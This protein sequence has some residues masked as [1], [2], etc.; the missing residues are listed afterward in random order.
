MYSTPVEGTAVGSSSLLR[1]YSYVVRTE[2]LESQGNPQHSATH[3]RRTAYIRTVRSS[4]CYGPAA[5]PTTA[6]CLLFCLLIGQLRTYIWRCMLKGSK[7]DNKNNIPIILFSAVAYWGCSDIA[8]VIRKLCG[9]WAIL[10]AR[11]FWFVECRR[12]SFKSLLCWW[13]NLDCYELILY[14]TFIL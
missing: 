10:K 4:R 5:H 1:R 9:N 2:R 8:Y 7:N 3:P 14:M 12:F 11:P 13:V 6:V